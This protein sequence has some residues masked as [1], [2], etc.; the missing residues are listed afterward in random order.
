MSAMCSELIEY[1]LT[2]G[3]KYKDTGINKQE[4]KQDTVE[5]LLSGAVLDDQRMQKLLKLL[6]ALD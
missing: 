1:A 2:H 6:D 3:D 5:A 4:I